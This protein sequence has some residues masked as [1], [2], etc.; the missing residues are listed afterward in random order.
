MIF[1]ENTRCAGKLV[2]EVMTWSSVV[3][4]YP[5]SE[6][7]CAEVESGLIKTADNIASL[8]TQIGLDPEVLSA[9][10]D[11]YNAACD[12]GVDT[13]HARN[14][15]TLLPI[16]NGPFYAVLITP[17]IVCTGGGARRNLDGQVFDHRGS[18]IPRLHEAGELGS[19]FSDLYQ[20]GS[21]LTE[22]MITGRRSARAA[23]ALAPTE[24]HAAA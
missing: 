9:E 3:R 2:L 1:D 21:Y 10:V 4:Q 17:S 16:A 12:A 5:W 23:L 24:I 6:D 11:S 7:N 19:M 22:A 20:N 18:T 14:P 13:V 15:E 8:A